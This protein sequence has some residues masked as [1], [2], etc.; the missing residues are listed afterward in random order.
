[1]SDGF[2]LRICYEITERLAFLS[3]LETIRSV[4]RIVRRAQLPF[5][6]TEGFNP[7]MKISFGPALPVGAGSK[8]EYVDLRMRE[9][10][11]ADRVLATLRQCAPPNLM[12]ISCEYIEMG[13]DAIDVAYPVSEWR[14]VLDA[15]SHDLVEIERAFGAL[16]DRGYIEVTKTKGKKV[17]T[18]RVEFAERLIDG[19]HLAESDRGIV[20]EFSTY[21]GSEGALRPDKFIVAAF[22]GMEEPP[23]LFELT[24]MAL[25][26]AEK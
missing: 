1:M 20:V 13:A 9:Y 8:G 4:E 23:E 18:K 24:R 10:I 25:R 22:E 12:P 17:S 3:H 21:Q 7:H 19:P 5:A 16:V 6:I 11:A 14:A 15:G 2:R 26:P